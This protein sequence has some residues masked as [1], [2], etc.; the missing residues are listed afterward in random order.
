MKDLLKSVLAVCIM[1]ALCLGISACAVDAPPAPPAPSASA[2]TAPAETES[3]PEP[4]PVP[5]ESAAPEAEPMEE[6]KEDSDVS[7]G[8]ELLENIY[9]SY[10]P[11]TAGSSLKAAKY[12]AMLLDWYVSIGSK[13]APARISAVRRTGESFASSHD[14]RPEAETESGVPV[15]FPEKLSAI[16]SSAMS[17]A[18]GDTAVLD[19]AGYESLCLWTASDADDLF[20]AMYEGLG[21][22]RSGYITVY[23][24]D[25]QV[26]YLL[27]AEIPAFIDDASGILYALQTAKAL[28]REVEILS[29]A[30]DEEGVLHL[31]MNR[32]LREYIYKMGTSGEALT[33]AALVDTF[34][35]ATG[36]QSLRLTVEGKALETGHAIY[37]F[38]LTFEDS[39]SG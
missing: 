5:Q 39:F 12:A 32:A 7:A 17:L 3:V 38:P 1:T 24:P 6:I 31:D 26:M 10:Y 9:E 14:L 19:D 29:C 16:W 18:F 15:N 2:V 23:Y 30:K 8:C 11:G 4:E 20:T 35:S 22:E 28:P 13:D 27:H 33:I 21:L 25:D 34:L 37:D 36:A